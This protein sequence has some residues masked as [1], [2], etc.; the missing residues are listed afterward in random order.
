MF[1]VL[2]KGVSIFPVAP[3]TV[4]S[5]GRIYVSV[6]GHFIFVHQVL[7]IFVLRVGF[8]LRF[9]SSVLDSQFLSS[10]LDSHKAGA[11]FALRFPILNLS[12]IVQ[13]VRGMCIEP[14]LL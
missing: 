10:M 2:K 3:S 9:L 14:G 5:V 1:L 7:S 13:G 4:I 11:G 8:A 12:F 6:S